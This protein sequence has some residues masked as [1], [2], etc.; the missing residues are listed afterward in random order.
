MA[1]PTPVMMSV[2]R[3]ARGSHSS[4]AGTPMIGIH[5]KRNTVEGSLLPVTNSSD[6]AIE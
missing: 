3:A 5:S 4:S 1:A 6:A 2:I